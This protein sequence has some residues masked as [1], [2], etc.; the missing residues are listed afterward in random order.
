MKVHP[1][2]LEGCWLALSASQISGEQ[3]DWHL[4]LADSPPLIAAGIRSL[5]FDPKDLRILLTN[6]AH[7]DHVG[8][9]AEM[10]RLT[11]AKI[12]ATAGDAPLLE[13]G[14]EAD[15]GGLG[16]FT[17]VKVD[18]VLEDGKVIRLG[19]LSIRVI[20][21]PGHTPGSAS[22]EL[23][24]G[25]LDTEGTMLFVN[26]PTVVM[27]LKNAKYPGI[28]ADLRRSF[29]RLKALHPDLWVA[30]HVSQ[31]GLLAK[32]KTGNLSDPAGYAKAV[33][34]CEADFEAKVKAELPDSTTRWDKA[35]PKVPS[36][37]VRSRLLRIKSIAPK[38]GLGLVD[39]PWYLGLVRD[40]ERVG[41]AL[42][43]CIPDM[44]P[45]SSP[46]SEPSL[47]GYTLGDLAF[48]VLCD[49]ELADFNGVVQPLV[50]AEEFKTQGA[51][52]AAWVKGSGRRVKL[53]AAVKAWRSAHT[54]PEHGWWDASVR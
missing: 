53:Q 20:S 42:V 36:A 40:R 38:V 50:G 28:V 37:A 43:A 34:D 12:Y 9:F 51:A 22:Y 18:R 4:H 52:Y 30:A 44:T 17:P 11:G 45:I 21:T 23:T 7:F 13:S 16:R 1:S 5:G 31:C 39:D 8:G 48:E 29:A 47:S 35:L 25:G 26:L 41:D 2:L 49:L 10:Q 27:P 6:Q 46:Y 33:A 14:G 3:P 15:P 19:N 54:S 24:Y 32:M